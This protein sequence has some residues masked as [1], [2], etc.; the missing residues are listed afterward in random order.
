MP[1][2]PQLMWDHQDLDA[3]DVGLHELI[4]IMSDRSDLLV[5]GVSEESADAGNG[6]GFGDEEGKKER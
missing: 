3:E 2:P 6:E 5:H 4:H 1:T